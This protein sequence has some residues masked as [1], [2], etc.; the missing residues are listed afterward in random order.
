MEIKNGKLQLPNVT[1][2][3][4][5]SVLVE[6]TIKAMEYSMREIDFG[7]AVIITH[8]KPKYLPKGIKYKYI[9]Y[10]KIKGKLMEM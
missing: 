1:L 5:T 8:K 7:D 3:A 10:D 2:C 4:M 6:E 9:D